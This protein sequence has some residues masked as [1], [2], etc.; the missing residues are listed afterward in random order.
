MDELQ[1][2]VIDFSQRNT[3][4]KIIVEY[5]WLGGNSMDIRSKCMTLPADYDLNNLPEWNYDG[6]ST[7]QASGHDSEV[8]LKPRRVFPD[9]FRL[10]NHLLVLCDTWYPDGT[11]TKS[12]FR[13]LAE[14]VFNKG[15]EEKP[16]YGIEQEYILYRKNIAWP[17]GFPLGGFPKPQG[18]YY[19][20]V[21]SDVIVGRSIMDAHYRACL[22]CGIKI[23]GTNAEVMPGQ[24]EFQV[25]PC[26]GISIG[27]ELWMARYLLLRTAELFGVTIS[28]HP[29]PVLSHEW[30]GSGCHTNYSTESTRNDGGYAVIDNYIKKLEANHLKYIELTGIDNE[31]RMSGKC[32]TSNL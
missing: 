7:N 27:D 15:L 21:G 10:G 23:S 2:A 1:S 30:N 6:S 14:E 16:W 29:K 3:N 20:G 12:N 28:W 17:L 25:G 8:I 5:I 22:H 11:R 13:V 18:P 19:C 4:D 24:W 9:P 32:E 26:L 31:K